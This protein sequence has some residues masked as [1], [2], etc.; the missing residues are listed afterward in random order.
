MYNWSTDEEKFKKEDPEGDRVW[1]LTQLIN[2]GLDG[3]KLSKSEI[4]KNWS[5]IKEKVD[6]KERSLIEFFYGTN[7]THPSPK[8]TFGKNKP[9]FSNHQTVLLY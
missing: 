4:K 2:Y 9:V 8:S 6:S 7:H 1:R 3:E 5:K